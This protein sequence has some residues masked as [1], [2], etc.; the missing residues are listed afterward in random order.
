MSELFM[1]I[2]S[3]I[4]FVYWCWYCLKK[5]RFHVIIKWVFTLFLM[6]V[7]CVVWQLLELYMDGRITNRPVDNIMMVLLMPLFYIT[8]DWILTKI[9]SIKKKGE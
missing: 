9:V 7:Y 3:F 4:F 2:I 8:V 5:R 1:Q 6:Y